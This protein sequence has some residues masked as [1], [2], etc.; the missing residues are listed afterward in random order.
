MAKTT[1]ERQAAYR[2]RRL[3]DG[4]ERLEVLITAAAKSQLD[5]LA[6]EWGLSQAQ[7]VE[8]IIDQVA[9]KP[10]PQPAPATPEAPTAAVLLRLIIQNNNKFVRGKK[11]AIQIIECSV[12]YQYDWLIMPSG[13]YLLSVP[14]TTDDDLDDT[15]NDLLSE[16]ANTADLYH[17]FSESDAQPK[18]ADR[19]W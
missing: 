15:I 19:Y 14:Y 11:R 8:R 7:T 10:S 17:C 6:Q 9:P 2:A 12:L 16:I 3:D 5:G 18:G 13:E 4:H 1:A